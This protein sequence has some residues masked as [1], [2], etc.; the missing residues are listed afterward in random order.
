MTQE[1]VVHVVHVMHVMG[2]GR[3]TLANPQVFVVHASAQ[4]KKK[5]VKQRKLG[6]RVRLKLV[7]L[8]WKSPKCLV[9]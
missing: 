8:A 4:Q 9:G 5:T 1:H 7:V 2:K 6:K 3:D